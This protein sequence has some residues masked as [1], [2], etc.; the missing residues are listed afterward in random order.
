MILSEIPLGGRH[1][2]DRNRTTAVLKVYVT[3]MCTVSFSGILLQIFCANGHRK[4]IWIGDS[5]LLHRGHLT[6]M[7]TPLLWRFS[8]SGRASWRIDQRK[9]FILGE[10]QNILL[11]EAVAKRSCP[12]L[13]SGWVLGIESDQRIQVGIAVRTEFSIV[14][15]PALERQREDQ[16]TAL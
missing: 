14:S 13:L 11:K 16:L 10:Q 1:M 15:F 6:S 9:A 3:A 2:A 4:K 5:I 8:P 7:V 12:L